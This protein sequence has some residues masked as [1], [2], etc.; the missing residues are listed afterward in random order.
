MEEHGQA[1]GLLACGAGRA[2]EA[3][4]AQRPAGFDQRGQQIF[5][6]QL[7]GTAV[8]KETGFVDGHGLGDGA[9]DAGI[10]SRL[11][12][13]DKLVETAHALVA[14][15]LGQARLEEVIARRIEHVL[16]EAEDQLAQIAVVHAGRVLHD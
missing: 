12:V 8:A 13:F 1:I 14:Q 3:Q 10:F 9:F 16:R 6:Q 11:E 15:Q 5:A 4:P 2:P 7:E